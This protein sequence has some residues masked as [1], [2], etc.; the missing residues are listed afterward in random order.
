MRAGCA[1]SQ[2]RSL[3]RVELTD[4]VVTLCDESK[5]SVTLAWPW[6]WATGHGFHDF[7]NMM[8]Y[9]VGGAQ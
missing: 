6:G 5:H 4:R 1:A 8:L 9:L 7:R 3:V 2:G